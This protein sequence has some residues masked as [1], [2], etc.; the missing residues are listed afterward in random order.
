MALQH[1]HF[2]VPQ[3]SVASHQAIGHSFD[4]AP[5]PLQHIG[6]D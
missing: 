6:K 5:L 2:P 3:D 1:F 4:K